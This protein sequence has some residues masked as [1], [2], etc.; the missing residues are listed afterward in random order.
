VLVAAQDGNRYPATVAQMQNGQYLCT[1][2][3]GQSYWF[4]AQNV[5]VG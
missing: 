2:Q 3:D 4:P 5:A 1:M